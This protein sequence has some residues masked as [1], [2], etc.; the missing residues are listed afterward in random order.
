[1][2]KILLV[3][4]LFSATYAFSQSKPFKIS[5]TI[6]AE[7]DKAPLESA[8]IYLETLKD[9]TLVTYTISD[10]NGKFT[11]ENSTY[12][13]SLNLTISYVGFEAYSKIV[14]INKAEIQLGTIELKTA[15]MLDEVVIKSRAPITIKKDTLEFNVSSFKTKKDANVEDLLKELPGVEV[16]EDGKITINGKE[17]SQIL[18]NG[19]PFFGSDP[20]ITTRNLTKE[21]IEKVQIVDTK[22]KSEAFSGEEGD[23]ENKTINLTIKEENNKGVF[24]R[25]SAGGG[26]DKRYEMAGMLNMFDNDQR[27]SVL[28]GGN[29]TNSPGFS[30][31]E[32]QKMFGNPNSMS[33]SS[34]GSFSIDGRSFGGGQGITTSQNLGANYADVLAK[35]IDV[36]GDYFLAASSSENETTT[37]RENIL[38]DSRYFTFSNSKSSNDTDNHSA[39]L[40]F[41]IEIDSTFLI[42]IAPKF[43][44]TKSKN[45]FDR[46]EQSFTDSNVLTNQSTAASFVENT[47]K[48]FG[49]NLDITKRFGNRG[50]FL[51]LS[52]D[53]DFNTT[54]TDDFLNS[55]TNVFGDDPS[56]IVRNQFTDG[57]QT[58][59]SFSTNLTYRL[60]IISKTF[61]I[62][63]KFDL[64]NTTRESIRST[65][66]FDEVSQGF[67]E[68]NDQLSTDFNYKDRSQKPAIGLS[69]R[70]EKWSASFTT[71]YV[72][73]TLENSDRLRP[74]LSLKQDFEALELN[75]NFNYRFSPTSSIYMG[76]YLNNEPPQISQLQPFQD[77]SDPL[78]TVTGNPNLEP[79]NNHSLYMGFNSFDFQK[80]TGFNIYANAD[81]NNNQVV[82]KTT[83][84]ENFVRNTTYENVNGSYSMYVGANYNSS[85]KIDSLKTI[86]YRLGLWSN[87]NR[88]INFNND[89]KYASTYTSLTPN[90]SITFNW[91]K[92]LEIVPNYRLSFT[93]N[94]FDL[95]DFDDQEFIRH[96]LGLRTATFV[97]KK[98]EWRNDINFI[99]NAN[100]APGFQKSAWFW[101]TTLAYS[102]LKEQGTVTLKVYDLLNQNTNAQRTATANYIQDSQ[103]TVLQQY[104][105]V[106]FSWKFNSLGKQGE[107]GRGDIYFFD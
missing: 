43:R 46:N 65:F 19:K 72:L 107:T 103:S 61:F 11:L 100:V 54:E 55:E 29:N 58:F 94:V 99:Y 17:V 89:V 102:V 32:I 3:L 39:N 1:M 79:S 38:P 63:F 76:Y 31:G 105:M 7:S 20:T 90:G 81:L 37:S 36:N 59:E 84:D 47:A 8:T 80:G 5:G 82:S 97:P 6:L 22:T 18:V 30:F 69:Y 85:F 104:F 48:N 41:D 93:K 86:K 106:S 51:K 66:D 2:K 23:T 75:S 24:G 45:S 52:V 4:A 42:N 70:K 50:A 49:N 92:V 78:N 57:E 91:N 13:D 33:M 62:D 21:I 25:V 83:I 96:S 98:L 95:D 68:F 9:T 40:E 73:R 87:T 77:V 16:D 88:N 60:P 15:N 56:D 34:N 35:G 12:S 67:N 44:L 28:A 101:N 14:A 53:T 27:I 64:N 10:K 26:T 71:G 74:E